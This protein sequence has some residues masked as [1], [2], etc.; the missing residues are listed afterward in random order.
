MGRRSNAWNSRCGSRISAMSSRRSCLRQKPMALPALEEAAASAHAAAHGLW[1][2]RRL[3][4]RS[5]A[6]FHHLPGRRL[7]PARSRRGAGGGRR[8]LHAAAA[9][10]PAVRSR[11]R[12]LGQDPFA[13]R[14][15]LGREAAEARGAGA[16]SHRRALHVGLRAGLARAR[17]ARLQ[18]EAAQ[19]RHSADRRHGVPARPDH[20]AGVLP[21]AEL[22]DRRRPAGRGGGRPGADPARQARHAHAVAA[23]RRPRGR[24]RHHGLRAP[25]QDPVEARARGVFR[26]ARARHL[27]HRARLP[28]RAPDRE[29]A[30]ARRRHPSLARELS[31]HR[32]A[33]DASRSPSRSC[34]I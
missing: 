20:P 5:E 6:D 3:A 14:H 32:R 31:A 23:W 21:H 24:D 2:L 30:R 13:A 26:D 19:D 11:Q 12:R 9:V 22:A 7:E 34:A 1:R 15:F 4:A 18:G 8:L 17:R 28:R 25:P 33:G 29:R 16:L 10:Q 27:R